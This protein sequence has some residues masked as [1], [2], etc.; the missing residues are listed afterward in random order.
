MD[1]TKVLAKAVCRHQEAPTG[2]VEEKLAKKRKWTPASAMSLIQEGEKKFQDTINDLTKQ[3]EYWRNEAY[4]A[5]PNP[6]RI[7]PKELHRMILDFLGAKTRLDYLYVILDKD[8]T[9]EHQYAIISHTQ[10]VYDIYQIVVSSRYNLPRDPNYLVASNVTAAQV[11]RLVQ[12]EITQVEISWGWFSEVYNW[13]T[14]GIVW[15][16][17]HDRID[18]FADQLQQLGLR[19]FIIPT[20]RYVEIE[21]D[22]YMRIR[23]AARQAQRKFCLVDLL[24][25]P[26]DSSNS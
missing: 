4:L 7:L 19:R 15:D 2:V 13:S 17:L 6:W 5:R 25:I 10:N 22:R 21:F 3:V 20:F 23:R 8:N 14:K 12:I 16:A 9:R 18:L 11:M 26:H 24:Q 1:R